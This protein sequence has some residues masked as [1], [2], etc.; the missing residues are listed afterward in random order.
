MQSIELTLACVPTDRSHPI[1]DGRVT[2][3]N[4][5]LKVLPNEPEEIF[6]PA[7]R[8]EAFDISEMSMCSHIVQIA[9][10]TNRYVAI[11]VFPA[12]SF[13]HSAIFIRTDRGIDSPT[14]LEGKTIGIPDYQ[15][16]AVL[17]VRGILRDI[18]GVKTRSIRWRTGGM[19]KPG[20]GS[21]TALHLPDD[22]DVAEIG[23][24]QSLNGAL[25]AGEI[26]AIISSRT[27]SCL[28]DAAAPVDRLFRDYR[29]ADIEY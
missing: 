12:R 23:S 3:P 28:A 29:K 27:P 16:T 7:L 10:N 8:D 25:A 19:E 6:G 22:V 11:P 1:L 9:Q 5:R 24:E 20:P 13:R 17:W 14:D 18:Y 21:R 26:D 4:V 15:Q 2:I